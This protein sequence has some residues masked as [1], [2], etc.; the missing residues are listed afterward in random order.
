MKAMSAFMLGISVITLPAIASAGQ[1]KY[2]LAALSKATAALSSSGAPYTKRPTA[3]DFAWSCY[4]DFCNPGAH[5]CQSGDNAW[6]CP[7]ST[8][9]VSTG[10]C[11]NY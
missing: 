6:C 10:S 1:V 7:N 5:C 8:I 4:A 9:C 3:K 11:S 2:K